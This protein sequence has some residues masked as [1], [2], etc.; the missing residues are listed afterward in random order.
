M[1]DNEGQGGK[2]RDEWERDWMGEIKR[3]KSREC[4]GETKV[5]MRHNADD[6]VGCKT[7]SL[8]PLMALAIFLVVHLSDGSPSFPARR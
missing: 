8:S 7:W 3:T 6:E 1:R 5:E 2:R 4:Q